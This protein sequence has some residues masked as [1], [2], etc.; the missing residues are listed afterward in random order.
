MTLIPFFL[1]AAYAVKLVWTG[2]TYQRDPA[3]AGAI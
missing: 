2:E 3:A 1:V